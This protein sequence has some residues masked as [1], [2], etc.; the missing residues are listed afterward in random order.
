[1]KKDVA[2]DPMLCAKRYELLRAHTYFVIDIRAILI[3]VL[4]CLVYSLSDKDHRHFVQINN[5]MPYE[6]STTMADSL[7]ET[8]ELCF[9]P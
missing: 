6:Q 1:M 9:Y 2:C 3:T 7:T 4:Q 5:D 8:I